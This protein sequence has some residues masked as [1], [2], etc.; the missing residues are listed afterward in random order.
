MQLSELLKQKR[1]KKQL[2]MREVASLV[3]VDTAIISKIEK[4]DRRPTKEQLLK[5]ATALDIDYNKLL[6]LWYS[7]KIYHEIKEESLALKILKVAEK[8]IKQELKNT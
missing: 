5:Y 1:E 4:G 2:L 6:T 3:D 7:D 8:R